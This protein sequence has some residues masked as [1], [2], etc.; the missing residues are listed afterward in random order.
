MSRHD[1][2]K[3]HDERIRNESSEKEKVKQDMVTHE[4]GL[5]TVARGED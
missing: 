3:R 2:T 5:V 1:D 4:G